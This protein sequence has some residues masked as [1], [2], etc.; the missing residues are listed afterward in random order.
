[1]ASPRLGSV[2][3]II[4]AVVALTRRFFSHIYSDAA[5][6]LL[7][8]NVAVVQITDDCL[9]VHVRAI[10][11]SVRAAI[12]DLIASAGAA[13][14]VASI[15]SSRLVVIVVVVFEVL[16]GARGAVYIF[17]LTWIKVSAVNDKWHRA[18]STNERLVRVEV[19]IRMY[20]YRIHQNCYIEKQQNRAIKSR[21]NLLYLFLTISRSLCRVEQQQQQQQQ[22]QKNN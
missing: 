2:L 1:M 20:L 9:L 5:R 19:L 13:V 11:E 16:F 15:K 7:L 22:Q 14:A 18:R 4:A 21:K 10:Q 12:V 6:L 17:W 8:V 3:F